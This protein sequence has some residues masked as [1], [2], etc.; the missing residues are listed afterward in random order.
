MIIE[1]VYIMKH[2]SC[3]MIS[4]NFTKDSFN[5][6]LYISDISGI[7]GSGYLYINAL[8]CFLRRVE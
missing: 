7:V 3:I 2:R 5:G 1:R 8:L 4:S 6:N